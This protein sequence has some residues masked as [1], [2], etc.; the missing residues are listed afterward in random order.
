MDMKEDM[1]KKYQKQ[2]ADEGYTEIEAKLLGPRYD[3]GPHTH[4]RLTVRIVVR[5]GLEVIDKE[6]NKTIYKM[7][8]RVEFAPGTT[9]TEKGGGTD[10]TMIVGYK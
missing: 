6:G 4:D 5:G 3:S 7:G 10:F 2:L 8:E 1:I 9:H